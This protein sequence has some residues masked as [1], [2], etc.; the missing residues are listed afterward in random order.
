M[1]N[2]NWDHD[3]SMTE[4]KN[5]NNKLNRALKNKSPFTY[6]QSVMAEI[7]GV[8]EEHPFIHYGSIEL[9]FLNLSDDNLL[10]LF[11]SFLVM[12]LD[13]RPK[14]DEANAYANAYYTRNIL[15]T[16]LTG[17]YFCATRKPELMGRVNSIIS[18]YKIKDKI[19][20]SHKV[21]NIYI[22][23]EFEKN[24]NE[25]SIFDMIGDLEEEI[26]N[27]MVEE[28]ISVLTY[29]VMY[30]DS[31]IQ[32]QFTYDEIE[33]DFD[34]MLFGMGKWTVELWEKVHPFYNKPGKDNRYDTLNTIIEIVGNYMDQ[35]IDVAIQYTGYDYNENYINAINRLPEQTFSGLVWAIVERREKGVNDERAF[36]LPGTT[37][38]DNK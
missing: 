18:L 37:Q 19:V 2:E 7:L 36:Y 4:W 17:Y 21:Y 30:D 25:E 26:Y 15:T 8:V 31:D 9:D 1:I 32:S 29:T 12:K 11:H 38:S 33:K 14:D 35:S 27:Y 24:K 10:K 28:Q 16:I 34:E 20:A 22:D 13:Y 6:V 3:V 23:D 5:K